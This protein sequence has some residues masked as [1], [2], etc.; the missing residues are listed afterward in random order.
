MPTR[1]L[2]SAAT[3][4]GGRCTTPA[5]SRASNSCSQFVID[6]PYLSKRHLRIYTIIYENDEPSEVDTLVYAEDLSQNG[7][8]WNGG[9]IGKGRGGFLLSDDDILRLS[10]HTYLVFTCITSCE[11]KDTFDLTQ[12][13]EMAV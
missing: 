13:L 9:F 10:R 2:S 4:P 6:D 8:Y 12:E 1:K 5:K 7:T 3:C 11:N